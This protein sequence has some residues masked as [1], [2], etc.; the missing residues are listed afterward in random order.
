M[1]EKQVGSEKVS[2]RGEMANSQKELHKVETVR[3]FQDINLGSN[4]DLRSK[5]SFKTL[6]CFHTKTPLSI[7]TP[8]LAADT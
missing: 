2:V 4:K 5:F 3:K 8:A 6:P 7:K 1:R